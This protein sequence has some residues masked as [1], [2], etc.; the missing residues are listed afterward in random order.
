MGR[1][2]YI[3]TSTWMLVVSMAVKI[4]NSSVEHNRVWNIH[5]QSSV[6]GL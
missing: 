5:G 4:G 2:R 3:I 6:L 1:L